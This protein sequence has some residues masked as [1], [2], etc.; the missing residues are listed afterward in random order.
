LKDELIQSERH[1]AHEFK[2]SRDKNEAADQVLSENQHGHGGYSVMG[3]VSQ[4]LDELEHERAVSR[5]RESEV[6]TLNA[7]LKALTE[8]FRRINPSSP[9]VYR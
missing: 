2:L 7:Q 4:L 9:S 6:G 3:K 8:E 5:S 1:L